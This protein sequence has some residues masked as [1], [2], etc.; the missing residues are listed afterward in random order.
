M[1]SI[2]RLCERH[3]GS[4][5]G[6]SWQT[7]TF[8]ESILRIGRSSEFCVINAGWCNAINNNGKHDCDLSHRLPIHSLWASIVSVVLYRMLFTLSYR[9]HNHKKILDDYDIRAS[10]LKIYFITYYCYLLWRINERIHNSSNFF[11][12]LM[13]GNLFTRYNMH[14]LHIKKS[15]DFVILVTNCLI[16]CKYT[17]ILK[18]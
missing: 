2:N 5:N 14:E 6:A 8:A 10:V 11:H 7:M 16:Y 13:F 9:A 17:D 12:W 4:V 1:L 18:G 15:N 3:T